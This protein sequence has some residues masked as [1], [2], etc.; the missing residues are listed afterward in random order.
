MKGILIDT[1]AII[2]FA[3]GNKKLSQ[4]AMAYLEDE[5]QNCFI[6]IVSL[7]EM[8]I[9]INLGKLSL[10]N[11]NLF[12]FIQELENNGFTILNI[13]PTHI[14]KYLDLE[15]IHK[16]PFDRLIITQ[17]IVENLSIISSDDVFSSYPIHVIW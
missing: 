9:K 17:A 4:A 5:R 16:D 15:L 12:E 7:W 3:E 10:S 14:V 1:Q 6:S 13:M 8:A 2:W 11:S